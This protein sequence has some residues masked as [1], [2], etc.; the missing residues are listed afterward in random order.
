[1]QFYTC[2]LHFTHAY[3]YALINAMH[4]L[5]S[6]VCVTLVQDMCAV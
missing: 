3:M 5:V 1:M 2:V 4:I 6:T